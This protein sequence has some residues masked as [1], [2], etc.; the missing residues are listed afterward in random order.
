LAKAESVQQ[1]ELG[2]MFAATITSIWVITLVYCLSLNL[3]SLPLATL[4]PLVLLRTFVQ[5]G[6]FI[7]GHDAMHGTL[8]AKS[9]KL[10]R[11]IGTAVLILYAGLNYRRCKSNHDLHHLE[12]ETE[13]DPDY[14]SHPNH[15]ALRWFWDFMSRYMNARPLTI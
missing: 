10:N 14:K 13:N 7:I 12:A 9:S 11:G 8:V 3:E 15:S 5:T 4:I 2:L 1:H 6:L